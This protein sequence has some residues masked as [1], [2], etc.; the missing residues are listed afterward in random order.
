MDG[1]LRRGE[2]AFTLI[3]LLVVVLIICILA[4]ILFPV[5]Q[6]AKERSYR[7]TCQSNM[8]QI[9]TAVKMYADDWGGCLPPVDVDWP[10]STGLK[11]WPG[12]PS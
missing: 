7:T 4:A 10:G 9:M 2:S 6:Q 12:N 11:T 8:K 1:S 3:E 5:L